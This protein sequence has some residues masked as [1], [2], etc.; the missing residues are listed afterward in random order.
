[1][2]W[3][4]LFALEQLGHL[5]D[6]ILGSCVPDG[7]T[8]HQDNVV[9]FDASR[10]DLA[11]RGTEH[12][13]GSVPLYRP[14]N[15]LAGDQ[16]RSTR[17]AG[18]EQHHSPPVHRPAI[19]EHPLDRRGAHVSLSRRRTGGCGPCVASRRGSL[20]LPACASADGSRGSSP[21]GGCSA[22]RCASLWPS[23]NPLRKGR[24]AARR[25]KQEVYGNIPGWRG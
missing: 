17:P 6:Q 1:M 9:T 20:G 12:P 19:A 10:R 7:L 3:A 25:P 16:R 14:A 4:H 2:S 5:L 15:L 23:R 22:G 13:T 8:S 11:E 18:D 21:C 24:S